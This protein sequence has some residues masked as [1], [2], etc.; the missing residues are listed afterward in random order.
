MSLGIGKVRAQR[1]WNAI[2][3]GV[4]LYAMGDLGGTILP[5]G[6]SPTGFALVTSLLYLGS[7][8]SLATGIT[9]MLV[10]RRATSRTSP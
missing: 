1:A 9:F 10:E 4:C 3:V 6:G 7:Y 2:A 5:E 8:L